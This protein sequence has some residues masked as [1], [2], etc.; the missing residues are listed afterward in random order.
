[1]IAASFLAFLSLSCTFLPEREEPLPPEV[2][3]SFSGEE[4]ELSSNQLWWED[5]GSSELNRLVTEAFTGSFNLRQAEAR[6][7]Q[8]RASAVIAGGNL[9]PEVN[10]EAAGGA[11]RARTGDSENRVTTTTENYSLGLAASYEIDLWGRVRSTANEADSLV[12]A[13]A[14]DLDTARITL[15]AEVTD[16]WLAIVELKSQLELVNSQLDSN[17]T[18]LELL[19]LR[20]RKGLASALAVFQQDQIVAGTESLIPLLES[21]LDTTRYELA[22][23]LGRP[24]RSKIGLTGDQ[25]PEVSPLPEIGLPSQLL[26]NRP[27]I[28]SAY[29]RLESSDWGVSAAR[30]NRLPALALTASVGYR[31]VE[32][33]DLF[34]NWFAGFAGALLAP[35][36]DGGRRSAEADR[37]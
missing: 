26:E 30:A 22:V 2:P 15:A 16:R 21:Q 35:L 17:R 32:F 3:E 27:D 4:G 25:I 23:L 29:F 31:S 36:I 7:S 12:L 1:M 28:R 24:P 19:L 8:A 14:A 9:Y 18:Y 10:L 11:T 37:V 5:F 34:D 6:L 33:S 20:Q 13:S